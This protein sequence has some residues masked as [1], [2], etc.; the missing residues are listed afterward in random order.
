MLLADSSVS[1]IEIARFASYVEHAE[2]AR[3]DRLGRIATGTFSSQQDIVRWIVNAR[4]GG[5][6]DEALWCSFLGAHFG[7]PLM[8]PAAARSAGRLLCGFGAEPQWQ[9]DNVTANVSELLRWLLQHRA[10]LDELEF[11]NHR[12]YEAKQPK[13][14]YDVIWGFVSWVRWNGGSPVDAFDTNAS[15]PETRFDQLYQRLEGL[16]R[17]GRL[18]CFDLLCLAADLELLPIRPASCYLIGATGPLDAARRLWGNR[19][20]K[21]L[22]ALADRTAMSLGVPFSSF[23]DALCNWQ[24]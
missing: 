13:L 14:L 8:E 6:Q 21:E 20:P 22:N 23:E 11:G 1:E 19:P 10:E 15:T 12:K 5:D 17:F 2:N 18:G 16:P 4:D 7:E 24:K 3:R 9:W